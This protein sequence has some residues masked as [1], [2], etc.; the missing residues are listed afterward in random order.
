MYSPF[1]L[2]I[3]EPQTNNGY[4]G[5]YYKNT[6]ENS[7]TGKHIPGEGP[8]TLSSGVFGFGNHSMSEP[9]NKTSFGIDKFKSLVEEKL[10]IQKFE[11]EAISLL[12][13]RKQMYPDK[14]MQKQSGT[15]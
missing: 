14:Q 15:G 7:K 2:C 10:D 13:N 1:N 4:E 12:N 11:E 8:K 5:L 3:F 9:F 6:Y